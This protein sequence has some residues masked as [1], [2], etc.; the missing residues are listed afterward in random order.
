MTRLLSK[1]AQMY[2]EF[3]GYK[4][5]TTVLMLNYLCG[6]FLGSFCKKFGYFLIQHLV[7]LVTY[8]NWAQQQQEFFPR[9]LNWSLSGRR[10][11]DGCKQH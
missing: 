6:H 10:V 7:T 11:F 5:K 4:A 2:G 9:K 3:L 1:V 8:I